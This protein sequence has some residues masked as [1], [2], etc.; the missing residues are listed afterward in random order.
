MVGLKLNG[1]FGGLEKVGFWCLE[2][3]AMACRDRARGRGRV[4]I[5]EELTIF[6]SF[7]FIE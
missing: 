4:G 1:A 3:E 5:Y 6:L 7:P 2:A